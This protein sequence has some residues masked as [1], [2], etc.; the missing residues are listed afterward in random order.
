[1]I[2]ISLNG[3]GMQRNF[4]GL[5][6]ILQYTTTQQF[7]DI[8]NVN[9]KMNKCEIMIKYNSLNSLLNVIESSELDPLG[10]QEF[11]YQ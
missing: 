10:V 4:S 8:K 5:W 11:F 1:M 2:A 7:I 6:Q 9:V 3:N